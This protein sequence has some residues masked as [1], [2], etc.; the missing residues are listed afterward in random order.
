MKNLINPFFSTY[1]D[2]SLKD[3][4]ND[5]NDEERASSPEQQQKQDIT[6]QLEQ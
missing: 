3:I 4:S 5:D 1:L 2:N 6:N